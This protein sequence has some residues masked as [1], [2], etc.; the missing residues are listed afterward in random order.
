[1]KWKSSSVRLN[2]NCKRTSNPVVIAFHSII[3]A[4]GANGATA[5]LPAAQLHSQVSD[6]GADGRLWR[7]SRWNERQF[8]FSSCCDRVARS[9]RSH[10]VVSRHVHLVPRPAPQVLFQL[11]TRDDEELL[12]AQKRRRG[13]YFLRLIEPKKWAGRVLSRANP[14][15]RLGGASGAGS[16]GRMSSPSSYRPSSSAIG[17]GQRSLGSREALAELESLCVTRQTVDRKRQRNK[18]R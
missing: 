1:M 5:F 6:I 2:L 10:R 7:D 9:A 11:F 17:C 16:H 14:R 12:R 4:K 8:A 3:D 15:R 13:H 18:N